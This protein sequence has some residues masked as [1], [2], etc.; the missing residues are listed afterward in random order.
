MPPYVAYV[1]KGGC[2]SGTDS[3]AVA[4][5]I[6]P[7]GPLRHLINLDT[8]TGQGT[9]TEWIFAENH[10]DPRTGKYPGTVWSGNELTLYAKYAIIT[11]GVTFDWDGL[12][13]SGDWDRSYDVNSTSFGYQ[14]YTG[15]VDVKTPKQDTTEKYNLKGWTG[16]GLSGINTD[17]SIPKGSI[18]DR[19]YIAEWTYEVT[20]EAGT[21]GTG[22]SYKQTINRGVTASLTKMT[23][24]TA[25]TDKEF[26][27]WNTVIDGSGKS[28]ED[29]ASV[30]NLGKITL[31][32]I[33]KE[34]RTITF[35][36]NDGSGSPPTLTQEV[37]NGVATSLNKNTFVAPENKIFKDWKVTEVTPAG[38]TPIVNTTFAEGASIIVRGGNV[39]LSAEWD[40]KYTITFNAN[41][42]SG[43]P[44]TS[45]QDVCNNVPTS[46][47]K[48]TF[49]APSGKIFDKWK[50]GES[51]VYWTD[52]QEITI[53]EN[54]TVYAQWVVKA[55]I[56]FNANGGTGMMSDQE[57]KKDVSTTLN[58]NAFTRS[59][60]TFYMWDTSPDG[61]G[62]IADKASYTP[63]GNVTLYA[64]WYCTITYDANTGTGGP[65]GPGTVYSY[66]TSYTLL[67]NGY[68]APT[69]LTFYGWNTRADG[70]GTGYNPDNT[71]TVAGDMTLY[72]IWGHEITFDYSGST[73]TQI[74]PLGM[75]TELDANEY[76]GT[77]YG[78]RVD[79]SDSFSTIGL[80]SDQQ[81]VTM[82]RNA[83]TTKTSSS[84]ATI[85]SSYDGA[86]SVMLALSPVA[87]DT[88]YTL[89]AEEGCTIVDVC[90]TVTIN[91]FT[92][93]I[94]SF[95]CSDTKKQ[96]LMITV[97]I[98]KKDTNYTLTSS[99]GCT[100]DDVMFKT[101]LYPI[102]GCSVTFDLNVAPSGFEAPETIVVKSGSTI[103]EP[104]MGLDAFRVT[105]YKEKACTNRFIFDTDTVSTNITLYAKWELEVYLIFNPLGI[106]DQRDQSIWVP[107]GE[108]IT[109]IQ[110]E[111]NSDIPTSEK[112]SS[113]PSWWNTNSLGR[114]VYFK[115]D[116]SYVFA[117]PMAIYG[118]WKTPIGPPDPYYPETQYFIR[119]ISNGGSGYMDGQMVS[120]DAATSVTLNEV[121]DSKLYRDGWTFYQWNLRADGTGESFTDGQTGVNIS[122]R[123]GNIALF[124]QWG[125]SVT[126]DGNGKTSGD[127]P[128]DSTVYT[129]G[130]TV[131]VLGNT[132]PLTKT[133]YTFAGWNTEPDGSG[134][135]YAAGTGTFNISV[136]TKLYALWH[137][138]VTL[139]AN[140]GTSDS[141]SLTATFNSD[142]FTAITAPTREGYTFLGYFTA[143]SAGIKIIGADDLDN[144][145]K[146][147]AAGFVNDGKWVATED[148][149]TLYAQWAEN[150]L[151]VSFNANG[152]TGTM[153]NQ[154][155][156]Y[157]S[158]TKT[159]N[160]NGFSY[161]GHS[162]NGWNT[163]AN[164]SGT[165]YAAGADV[166]ALIVSSTSTLVLYA[167]WTTP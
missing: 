45:T 50:V 10:L 6:R 94:I 126:Y 93:S 144:F 153:S 23:G 29:G 141:T 82:Y 104:D 70:K 160:A 95:K 21:G 109:S 120:K 34:K 49:T 1:R 115:S 103:S 15:T 117:Y 67:S 112:W 91:S 134:T 54:K 85:Q 121:G 32:A 111:I 113:Y 105:W 137:A 87:I 55:T 63:T 16:T 123:G 73:K 19:S 133:G 149:K 37:W 22:V 119:Y 154:V 51:E 155:I 2:D 130:Q 39:T 152:G 56:S 79:N 162:F 86:H 64:I 12:L 96:T 146:T 84:V 110:S 148:N 159:L 5:A 156:A 71:I 68:T 42:G 62:T 26:Y 74:I 88:N 107:Y 89:T 136:N 98:A 24:F 27:G 46:L 128:T 43:S 163:S 33:W 81:K 143:S 90:G 124:A 118:I 57:C 25:P 100:I 114:G 8:E 18:G 101:R 99:S 75:T 106:A 80:F 102:S 147:T 60:W 131:T 151:M 140:G 127:V 142:A 161:E 138:T 7:P 17:I 72:A 125:H 59:G 78:W 65:T 9:G 44:P 11:Y 38:T 108:P 52:G 58:A 30:E 61:H 41:D 135:T 167:Q 3:R 35:N 158:P 14:S 77:F 132:G 157:T 97:S 66:N 139:D 31:Y 150:Q 4:E 28:Y 53:N 40:T 20:F 69:G 165:S 48:N 166:S 145:I 129:H 122:L 164:G 36:A 76:D 92:D 13:I 83:T 116:V 47:K